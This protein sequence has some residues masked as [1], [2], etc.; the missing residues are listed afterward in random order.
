M[1][2][3]NLSQSPKLAFLASKFPCIDE[4]FILREMT[5]LA[6]A[7]FD[8]DIY[9]LKPP[10]DRVVQEQ[11]QK[12]LPRVIY[13]PFFLSIEVLAAQFY[14]LLRRPLR[15]MGTLLLLFFEVWHKPLSLLK[16]LLL[17][18]KAVCFARLMQLRKTVHVHAFWATFPATMAWIAH[19]LTGLPYSLSAHAHDIY[20]DDSML[21]RKLRASK[22]VMTCTDYNRE[23]LSKLVPEQ[24]AAIKLIYHG[25]DLE[26]FYQDAATRTAGNGV[27]H[28]LSI[29]TLFNTKGFDTL[30]ETCALLKKRNVAFECKIVGDGP[31]R[32]RLEQ[33]IVQHQ[34]Q[35]EVRMLGYLKQEEL[36]PLR[37]WA[38][39]FILLP[40]PY[41]HWGIPNVYIEALAAKLPVIATPLNAINELVR[42]G[43]TGMIVE[44]DDPS[45]TAEALLGISRDPE[46]NAIMATAGQ[47]LVTQ[48]FDAQ[49]TSP[50][51]IEIFAEHLGWR[52]AQISHRENNR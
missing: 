36:R 3:R 41:L 48:K 10:D 23:Y 15:Y 29:G 11:A 16:C 28:I 33:L 37:L 32:N 40:R 38:S 26:K 43:Q 24:Q 6:E 17:F 1:N 9:S 34:L 7:G 46:K 21:V 35:N 47:K 18:P 45:A 25:L 27:L 51:V 22:F 49:Q 8:F 14:F 2:D 42:H 52:P 50:Q 31:E 39:V 13:R 20:E 30:I 12:L 4:T 19:R 44:S 5:V